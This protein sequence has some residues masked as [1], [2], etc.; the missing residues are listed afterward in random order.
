LMGTHGEVFEPPVQVF[1]KG[2]EQTE[3]WMEDFYADTILAYDG[4]V[5]KVIDQLKTRGQ[6][7]STI[8]IINTDHNQKW[9][10]NERI[11]LIIHFPDDEY[12]GRISQNVQNMD[13]A[14]T[15]L[16]YLGLPKPDWMSGESLLDGDLNSQRL[17]FSMGTSDSNEYG[18]DW[19]RLNSKGNNPL[20][21]HL[22]YV[23]IIECQKWYTYDLKTFTWSSGDIA[24][25]SHPCNESSLLS[26][27]EIKEAMVNRLSMDGFDISSLP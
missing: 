14:P 8:L 16:D 4:Y 13:I 24:G 23:N 20:A 1:S 19:F 3:P 18:N 25:Y 27:D 10:A 17:I 6:F 15:I 9:R 26:F 5:G 2:E 11:P 7:D 21:Y 12:A 22:G